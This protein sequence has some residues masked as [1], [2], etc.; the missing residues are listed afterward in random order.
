MPP[1]HRD[2]TA[3]LTDQCELTIPSAR[4][5]TVRPC[6][7]KSVLCRYKSSGT[8]VEELVFPRDR[9]HDLGEHD[10]ALPVP[11]LREGHSVGRQTRCSRD[12]SGSE[13]R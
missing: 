8:A 5:L 12:A 10:R 2:S 11:S 3:L 1:A 6:G 9:Q 7:A 13:L 4:W